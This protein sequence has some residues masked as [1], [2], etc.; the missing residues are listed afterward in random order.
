MELEGVSASLVGVFNA[1]VNLFTAAGETTFTSASA[2]VN[3]IWSEIP[4]IP[5]VGDH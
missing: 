2:V 5:I 1:S 4:E 3:G